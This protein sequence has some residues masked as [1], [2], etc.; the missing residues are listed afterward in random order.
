MS[1]LK[2]K[3]VLFDL[4][5]TLVTEFSEGKR[6]SNRNYDYFELLGLPNEE[7]KKEWR[8]RSKARMTGIFPD[9]PS[10]IRDILIKRELSYKEE[11]IKFLYEERMREKEIPFREIK[12]EIIDLLS[13]LKSRKVSLGL[14]SNC[15]EEEVRY[16]E[17]SGLSKYFDVA[18]FSYEVGYAKPDER[19]Y[20]LAC[21]HLK[22]DP[23]ESIFV[24]DGGSDELTGAYNI[25]LTPI[26][27]M[28]FNSYIESNFTKAADPLTLTEML[29]DI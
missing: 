24:G 14:V 23:R 4:F 29:K 28:W 2:A 9:Y 10:V 27:A 5:E 25:G 6:I 11:S 16:W 15:T 21:N 17:D 18:I 12:P 13:F 19:I 1:N 3:A 20:K 7:Y 26:Q 22:V 8:I